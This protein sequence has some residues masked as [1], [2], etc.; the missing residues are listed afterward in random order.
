MSMMLCDHCKDLVD[1]DGDP[2]SLYV[3]DAECLC[4]LCRE[5]QRRPS[6]FE[7]SE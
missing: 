7:A 3:K 2:D 6:E 1:T 4:R 5:E